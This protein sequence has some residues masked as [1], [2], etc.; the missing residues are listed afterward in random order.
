MDLDD[1]YT[2]CKE[3]QLTSAMRFDGAAFPEISTVSKGLV[4]E[5]LQIQRS[6][7]APWSQYAHWMETLFQSECVSTNAIRRSVVDL[8]AKKLKIQKDPAHKAEVL[9]LLHEPF[10]LPGLGSSNTHLKNL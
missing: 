9:Q 6:A 2:F 1:K 5:L 10:S 4:L 8:N 3:A 7:A